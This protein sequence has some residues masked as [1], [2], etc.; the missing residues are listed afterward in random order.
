MT[1]RGQLSGSTLLRQARSQAG[2]TLRELAQLAHTSH[3]AL[4][5]YESG[6]KTPTVETFE[7]VLTAAG[8]AV[9]VVLTPRIRGIATYERGD[10]LRD[11]LDL[12]EMF[13]ARHARRLTF[14]RFHDASVEQSARR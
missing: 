3:S 12:A 14:P 1:I 11:V 4:A 5:A 2:L 8:F 10:E 7:R 6:R 9:D 13:P